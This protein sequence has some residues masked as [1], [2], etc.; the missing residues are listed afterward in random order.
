MGKNPSTQSNAEVG[1]ATSAGDQADTSGQPIGS[2][3]LQT[4]AVV[5]V[6]EFHGVGGAYEIVDGVRRRIAGPA[7]PD[8]GADL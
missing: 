3:E 5:P 1:S 8:A 7:L 2:P 4:G 6:D